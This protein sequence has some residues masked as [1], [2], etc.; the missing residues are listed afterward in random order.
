MTYCCAIKVNEGIVYC[1]DSRT[2]AGVDRVSTYSKMYSFGVIGER[3][4]TILSA[5][6]L[7]TTQ[8]VIAMAQK[9]IDHAAAI[10]LFNVA[11]TRDAA[12]Y[13]G[14]LSVKEQE[15]HGADDSVYDASFIIGGQIGQFDSHEIFLVYPEGNCISTSADTP[16]LQIGESKY[17]KPILDRII[18]PDTS[19]N[20]AASAALVSMDST[21]KSNLTVGPPIEVTIY[22][23]NPSV[24]PGCY[25]KFDE[26]SAYLRELKKEWDHKL[27]ESFKQLPPIA[28]SDSWDQSINK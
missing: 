5:G 3:Q 7:A 28:W 18:T 2:N 21:M 23:A 22:Q 11:S 9:D 4:L 25:H 13:L 6:N 12:D 16:F 14:K 20:T 15:K 24:Q 1:S 8:A 19:L 26:E 10:N 27:R 17:G